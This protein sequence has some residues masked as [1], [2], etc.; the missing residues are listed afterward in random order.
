MKIIPQTLFSLEKKLLFSSAVGGVI[1]TYS[2]M[3]F[4]FFPQVFSKLFF[5]EHSQYATLSVFFSIFALGYLARPLGGILISHLGDTQ[6]RIKI[7]P[8]LSLA[9]AGTSFCVGLMPTY[10]QIGIYAPFLLVLLRLLQGLF[11]GGAIP[12]VMT[13]I[14]EHAKSHE[15]G[16]TV[17]ILIG[18]FL[19]GIFLCSLSRWSLDLFPEKFFL[20]YGWRIPFLLSLPFGI[21][22]WKLRRVLGETPLFIAFHTSLET[23]KSPLFDLIKQEFKQLFQAVSILAF[24]AIQITF[25][26]LYLPTYLTTL[27]HYKHSFAMWANSINLVTFILSV[28]LSGAI[29][30][31]I[32]RK[33]LFYTS[34][35]AYLFLS[36]PG[37][38]TLGSQREVPVII[39]G[40]VLSALSGVCWG[41]LASLIT[42][43]FSTPVRLTG[44]AIS[45]N[46]GF[47]IFGGMLPLISTFLIRITGDN[48]SPAY[49]L[50]ACAILAYI[51]IYNVN[52]SYGQMLT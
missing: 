20:S 27:F 37:V 48:S 47:A 40:F 32:G 25:I 28:I 2:F 19:G 14:S 34:I 1:E 39:V 16:K 4:I 36:Y 45:F 49:L 44:I 6:G 8:Y 51:G 31:R 21:W 26:F 33:S 12:T 11:F 35:I 24:G 30:D 42:E 23:S 7:Y 13:Y 29:S 38:L 18:F 50:I 46:L 43:L 22:S 9:V 3:L 52:D 15:R 17:A 10:S 5:P 41:S